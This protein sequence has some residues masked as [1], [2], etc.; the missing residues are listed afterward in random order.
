MII[1]P[2]KKASSQPK[3][4]RYLVA[5]RSGTFPPRGALHAHGGNRNTAKA[6]GFSLNDRL[7]PIA[8]A[9]IH[10]IRTS[11]RMIDDLPSV[12]IEAMTDAT[13][14]RDRADNPKTEIDREFKNVRR[15]LIKYAAAVPK[16]VRNERARHHWP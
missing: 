5:A 6:P 2:H 4:D 16:D 8:A 1:D 12:V 9:I 10:N 11:I 15:A 3:H 13:K 14:E 7:A